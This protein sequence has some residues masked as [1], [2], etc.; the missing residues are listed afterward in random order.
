MDK[1]HL[2]FQTYSLSQACRGPDG[3]VD[4]TLVQWLFNLRRKQFQTANRFDVENELNNNGDKAL[5]AWEDFRAEMTQR[6]LKFA[7]RL[8]VAK[9]NP[10]ND[11]LLSDYQEIAAIAPYAYP[12]QVPDEVLLF[13]APD[14]NLS[15]PRPPDIN[16]GMAR[17]MSAIAALHPLPGSEGRS[18][19][20]SKK[21]DSQELDKDNSFPVEIAEASVPT[22]VMPNSVSGT[23][24]D[25]SLTPLG[26][27]HQTKPEKVDSQ[28]NPISQTASDRRLT[29]KGAANQTWPD[30]T[31]SE[32]K[33]AAGQGLE[34]SRPE[35]GGGDLVSEPINFSPLG[36]DFQPSRREQQ[37]EQLD[38]PAKSS[39]IS[40][41]NK[42][43]AGGQSNGPA[44]A[45]SSLAVSATRRERESSLAVSASRE[46][47]HLRSL[48]SEKEKPP[49]GFSLIKRPESIPEQGG[50]DRAENPL[51]YRVFSGASSL[52]EP[53]EEYGDPQQNLARLAKMV[54]SV[55]RISLG[56]AATDE[57]GYLTKKYLTKKQI[58]E[59]EAELLSREPE[60]TLAQKKADVRL[61][62]QQFYA[63]REW[64]E[65][66]SAQQ[67]Q[68]DLVKI[69][70]LW[71]D[72]GLRE[73]LRQAIAA[74]PAWGLRVTASG[75]EELEF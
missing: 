70:R 64:I 43:S 58:L 5:R 34:A 15:L 6:V 10:E 44:N 33:L 2:R 29:P 47:E 32:K 13:L 40:K 73:G 56:L 49:K 25:R 1:T 60:D 69:Q 20:I 24:S 16:E 63:D 46:L 27:A 59:Q 12:E 31:G 74:H 21:P 17:R 23:V 42:H 7:E 65:L 67:E 36:R 51:A 66:P 9:A 3:R 41:Q 19:V 11:R 54:S 37:P 4:G 22:E 8:T 38:I 57:S 50:S 35:S 52:E 61:M 68:P 30:K 55:K 62:W 45:E 53:T 39:G 26:G 75:V 18:A 28:T 71:S 14:I 48:V 72:P